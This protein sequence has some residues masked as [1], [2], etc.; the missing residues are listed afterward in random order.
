M[1]EDVASAID[2]DTVVQFLKETAQYKQICRSILY[3]QIIGQAA[4]ER[5]IA[6]S[7]EEIQ[8]EADEF[9]RQ[10][11]LERASD[12]LAWLTDQQMTPEDWEKGISDRLLSK[13][14]TE[15]M[16]GKEVEKFFTENRLNFD[17]VSLYQMTFMDDKL[18][19]E[20]FYQI[21]EEEISFYEAARLYDADEE[22]RNRC[23][24]E[25]LTYRWA[26]RP[27]LAAVI[28][29]AEPGQ[30]TAP[31]A[32]EPGFHLLMIDQ[33]V[34]AELTDELR[35][36]LLGKLFQEWLESELTYKLHNK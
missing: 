2:A 5:G 3:Q 11:R 26:L 31:I 1:I 35:Q 12:T 13:K 18:A 15:T 8:Q 17:R 21:E 27:E 36:E 20:V 30:V 14:L 28:F 4:Q 33:F 7:A 24:Y 19:Q 32:A 22:R 16:F 25:G 9:R 10:N 34:P 29:A 6:V 23:G